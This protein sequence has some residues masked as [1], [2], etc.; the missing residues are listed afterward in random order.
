MFNYED[1]ADRLWNLPQKGIEEFN[2]ESHYIDDIIQKSHIEKERLNN[3]SNVSTV[4]D[5]GAGA[6]RFS[7]F[8]AKRGIKVTHF[9]ISDSMIEVA[10]E[11]AESEGVYDK[12]Q[13]VKGRLG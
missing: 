12:I 2:R 13:F 10:K 1:V 7:I 9:D 3:L 5:G 4:F 8:L 6:G 11:Y